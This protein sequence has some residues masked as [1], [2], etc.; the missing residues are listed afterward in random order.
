MKKI[1][2]FIALFIYTSSFSQTLNQEV[3]DDNG[4][5]KLLGLIDKNGLTKTPYNDWFTKNYD[6]Y[7]V[8]EALV[9]SYKDSLNSY[10]IKA[11][12]G[13]WC[14]D[15]KREVPRFYKVLETANFNMNNLKVFALD[16]TKENYKKGPNGEEDGYNIHRVPTFIFYKNGKEVNRI[17]EYPKE[18]LER[19]IENIVTNKRYF[20][21]YFVA[22]TMFYNILNNPLENLKQTE[23]QFL[24]YFAEYVNGSKE[25]NSLGYVLLRA[26]KTEEALFVFEFNTKLFPLN[27]NVY[28]S[29]AETYYNTNNYNEA[30]KNYYKVLSMNPDNENA[31]NM[32]EKMENN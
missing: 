11:F 22:N 4:S 28:D 14:G 2:T 15:S 7:I 25:L 8:N 31:K 6:N 17:V 3:K 1:I 20:P 12:L 5:T 27:Y 23:N 26:K 24:P 16:N 19:D 29:L 9:N 30:I 21:N 18:T 10:T 32:I 13:T